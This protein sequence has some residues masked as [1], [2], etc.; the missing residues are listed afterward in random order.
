MIMKMLLFL[1][2]FFGGG[3]GGGG[4]VELKHKASNE[5]KYKVS[6]ETLDLN[7]HSFEI[8]WINEN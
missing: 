2:F 6:N 7:D 4:G 5:L 3:G 1:S 8:T